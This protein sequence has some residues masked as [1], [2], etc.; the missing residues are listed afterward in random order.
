[1]RDER[2]DRSLPRQARQRARSRAVGGRN[3]SSATSRLE[4]LAGAAS[5]PRASGRRGP[6]C[7]R[8]TVTLASGWRPRPAEQLCLP[9]LEV[10]SNLAELPELEEAFRSGELS[11]AQA[12]EVAGAAIVS[13]EPRPSCSMPPR[14]ST[15]PSCGAAVPRS[16]PPRPRL[17]TRP[18]APVACTPPRPPRLLGGRLQSPRCPS[19]PGVPLGPALSDE[20]DKLFVEARRAGVREK[21]GAY[22]ADAL[23]C[24][25]TGARGTTA[26]PGPKALV[27]LRVDLLA[28]RR[29]NTGPGELCDIS[30]ASARSRSPRPVSCSGTRSP[31]SW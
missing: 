11:A 16:K 4:R 24:L 18:S 31:A 28:L 7:P 21:S 2:S 3:L 17:R 20:A 8:G 22:L 27:H 12:K 6:G 25:V 19:H 14:R 13:L 29:G 10:A 30:W 9:S 1:M 5:C 23:L 26:S 15:S